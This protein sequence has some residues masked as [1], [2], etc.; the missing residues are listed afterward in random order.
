MAMWL[1][2]ALHTT[3]TPEAE[4]FHA[5]TFQL[6]LNGI[7]ASEY[8]ALDRAFLFLSLTSIAHYLIILPSEHGASRW[9]RTR[10]QYALA[11]PRA[12]SRVA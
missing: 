7:K 2:L 4:T 3:S 11:R 9:D 5:L 10:E 8:R 1:L 6:R 12:F